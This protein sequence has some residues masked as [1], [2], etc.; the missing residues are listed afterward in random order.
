MGFPAWNNPMT[1]EDLEKI[2]DN[3]LRHELVDGH[4]V[5]NPPPAF[6]HHRAVDRLRRRLQT[7]CD[8]AGFVVFENQ[9]VRLGDDVIVPDLTVYREDAVLERDIYIAGHDILLVIEVVSPS[10]RRAD[11]ITKPIRCARNGVPLYLLVDPTVS[12][13]TATLYTLDGIDYDTGTEVKAG[14]TLVLPEPFG[15]TIDT[16]LL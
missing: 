13:L 3:G 4:I 16:A 5:M 12:P 9:G 8:E 1:V 15:L 10:T 11:R 14:Q 2:P 7:R 6:R